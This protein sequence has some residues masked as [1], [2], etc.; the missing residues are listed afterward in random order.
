MIRNIHAL[1]LGDEKVG[2]TTL[3]GTIVH[4]RFSPSTER[5]LEQITIKASVSP[6]TRLTLIDTFYRRD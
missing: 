3:I 5:V 6:N 2:K 4:K 1:F